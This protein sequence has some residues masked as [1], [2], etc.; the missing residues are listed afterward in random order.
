VLNGLG[1]ACEEIEGWV[2]AIR[3]KLDVE[4]LGIEVDV[5]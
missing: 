2:R 3:K 4:A 5:R 1:D